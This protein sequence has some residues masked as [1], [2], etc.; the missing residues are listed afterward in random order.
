[1]YY[2]YLYARQSELLATT[3]SLSCFGS[4][5]TIVPVFEPVCKPT[6]LLG[7]LAVFEESQAAAYVIV[8][9]HQGDLKSTVAQADWYEAVAPTIGGSSCARA[10]FQFRANT[11]LREVGGF[12]A[13][14]PEGP[15]AL[16]IQAQWLDAS[17]LADVVA[18]RDVLIFTGSGADELSC[19]QAFG[20]ERIVRVRDNF[21]AQARNADYGG[22]ERLGRN[23]LDYEKSGY[24]GFSDFT[25]LPA[26]FSATG[27]PAGAVAIHLTYEGPKREF[28]IQ[29]FVSDETD[30]NVGTSSS[31]LLEALRYLREQVQATP[32]RFVESPALEEYLRQLRDKTPTNLPT[33]KKLQIVHHLHEVSAFLGD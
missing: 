33:N 15:I 6:K 14:F 11:T 30:R 8:N 29:H 21:P 25:V 10:A 1:M 4:P 3:S 13:S 20:T 31:K 19:G 16:V 23:H 7:A 12:E 18:G 26:T 9:P 32:D 27:G 28:W 5:Q 22:E 17:D 2:P 24:A